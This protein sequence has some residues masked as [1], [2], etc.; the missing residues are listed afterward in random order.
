MKDFNLQHMIWVDYAI[1]A[2]I[3]F[4]ALISLIRGFVREA[5]S[6]VTWIA[7][8]WISYTYS[9]SFSNFFNTYIAST[10]MRY[11]AAFVCLFI[12]ML[13]LGGI[14]NYFISQLVD[15]TG[16]SGTDR[17]VG[18]LFGVVRGVL[19]VAVMIMMANLTAMPK[20]PWWTKSQL[21]PQFDGIE[22]WLKQN[23]P[24]RFDYLNMKI[25]KQKEL[26]Q[27]NLLNSIGGD[28][29]QDFNSN[30]STT[31]QAGSS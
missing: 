31:N 26:Q 9:E 29:K 10:S 22:G 7:A 5:I 15:R 16:L 3:I 6:L 28:I 12:L 4:S 23:V 1:I 21:I 20:D 19:L 18:L 8:L 2:I 30:R 14:I 24:S 13:I 17:L 11:A 27:I 25:N